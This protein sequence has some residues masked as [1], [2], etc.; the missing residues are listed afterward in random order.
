MEVVGA[1]RDDILEMFGIQYEFLILARVTST[2]L[3][4][5]SSQVAYRYQAEYKHVST[6]YATI[7]S[8]ARLCVERSEQ[9]SFTSVRLAFVVGSVL[10]YF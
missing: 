6:S 8:D 4:R 1:S 7:Q 5:I 10:I 2:C 3:H 9:G